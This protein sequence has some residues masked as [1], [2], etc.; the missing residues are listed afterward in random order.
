MSKTLY[1][2]GVPPGKIL[3]CYRLHFS[4]RKVG[5]FL[6]LSAPTVARVIRETNPALLL[7]VGGVKGRHSPHKSYGTFARWVREHPEVR[8]PR[9]LGR[10]AVMTGCS[11]DSIKCFLY[12]ARLRGEDI[13]YMKPYKAKRPPSKDR[14]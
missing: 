14:A 9:D 3:S 1:A 5:K 4:T 2:R 8:F 7:G 13:P 11:R 12:R 6:G 10:I